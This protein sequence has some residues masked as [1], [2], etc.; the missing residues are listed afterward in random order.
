VKRLREK[1]GRS[2]II[3]DYQNPHVTTM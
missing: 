2:A 1:L 3:F